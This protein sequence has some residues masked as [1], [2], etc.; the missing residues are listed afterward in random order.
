MSFRVKVGVIAFATAACMLVAPAAMASSRGPVQVT[1]KQLK[2]A[3]LPASDFVAGYTAST[4][5]DTG[6]K[7]E[8]GTVFN[9]R[10]MSCENF[11]LFIGTT[12]GFG[13]T[14]FASD[15]VLDKTGTKRPEEIFSQSVYQFASSAAAASFYGKV[16][17]KY[18]SCH[19]VSE[20]DGNGGTTRRTA[21]SQSKE[22]V[23][24]HQ[25]T[26]IIEY[27][28]DSKIPGPALRIYLLWTVDGTDIYVLDT[29]PLSTSSPRP[30]QSS[31]TLKLIA[32]VAALR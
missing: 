15:L 21:H 32:R 7:L 10:T 25:A 6:R 24:G 5:S 12:F 8:H 3:L 30:A 19:S 16:N 28:T 4:E 14:A 9:V 22:R 29:T 18:K 23:G 27:V 1:G 26:Q 20:S 31:L 13:E 17:A 11:W 2:P